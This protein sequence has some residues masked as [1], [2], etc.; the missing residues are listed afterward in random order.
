MQ[1]V[2]SETDYSDF[3]DAGLDSEG[4][5]IA[6]Y[7]RSV[8]PC[9]PEVKVNSAG[10]DSAGPSFSALSTPGSR[11]T[12]QALAFSATTFDQWSTVTVGWTFGDGG[13]ASGKSVSHAFGGA[14]TFNVTAKATDAVGNV[15][16]ATR[17]VQIANAPNPGPA[18]APAR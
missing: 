10:L 7:G 1:I 5:G 15:A 12:G 17:V 3:P 18:P 6:F 8:A 13:T 14:G 16:S 2:S 11:Q 9:C 4:N